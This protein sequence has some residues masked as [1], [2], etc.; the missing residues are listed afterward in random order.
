MS[1]PDTDASAAFYSGLF[2]WEAS[3]PGPV[4]ET[5]GYRMFSMRGRSVAGLGPTREGGPPPMWTTYVTVADADATCAAAAAAGGM[6]FMQPMDVLE[7]GR[8]A[9]IGD[10]QGAGFA[11][12]QPNLHPGSQV[13]NEPGSLIW[14]ELAVRDTGPEPDFYRAVFGWVADTAPMGGTEYTTWR[15]GDHPVGGMIRMDEQWPAEMPPHWMT[16]FAVEDVDAACAQATE[17]GATVHVPPKDIEGVGRFAVI[18]DPHGAVFSV[19]T[20]AAA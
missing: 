11:I 12:W 10:P 13:V 3:E 17:L 4:E 16:Y 7:A 9:V 15:L 20:M 19:I 5:G 6:V 18:G 8:M 1:S 14:S 2:G